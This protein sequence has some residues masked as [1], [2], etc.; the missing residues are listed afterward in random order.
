MQ[1]KLILK[2]CD[3]VANPDIQFAPTAAR[4]VANLSTANVV[5]KYLGILI[6]IQGFDSHLNRGFS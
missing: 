5:V 3:Y 2:M 6:L 4:K 1:R